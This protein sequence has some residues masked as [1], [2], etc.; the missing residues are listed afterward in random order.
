M[1][2]LCSDLG[3]E[4]QSFIEGPYPHDEI[5]Q[6]YDLI[7]IFVVSRPDSNVTRIVPPIKPLEAM[8]RQLPT[9]VSDLPALCEIIEHRKTGMTF[10]AQDIQALSS[11][12]QE[13]ASNLLEKKLDNLQKL[14]PQGTD[15][16]RYCSQL[17]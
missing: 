1:R 14:R 2:N 5:V 16:A 17:Q 6:F 4:A 8:I 9:V 7:D 12:I 15:M 10:P 13:L 11:V 3:I